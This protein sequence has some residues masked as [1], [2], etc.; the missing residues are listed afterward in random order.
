MFNRLSTNTINWIIIIGVILFIIEIAF[1]NGGV[2]WAALIFGFMLYLGKKNYTAM[3]GKVLF[4]IGLLSLII[5]ILNMIAIRFLIIVFIVL[6]L[7]DY[8]RANKNAE[9]IEPIL[10]I[11]A[12]G[13]P[14][15]ETIIKTNPI[16]QNI[17]FGDQETKETAYEW[18]DINIH[19]GVGNRII[20]LSNTVLPNDTAVIS[21][22]HLVGNITIY[23]PYE[24][25][26][27]I[28]H[29]A[30]FGRVYILNE[31]HHHL[32]NQVL[33]YKTEFYETNVPRVKII[34]SILSGN[35]EVKRI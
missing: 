25:E 2:L 21:I 7:I 28:H 32:M 17:F 27:M 35:V 22:R 10:Y 9:Q 1:F 15:K 29:S 14:R 4:W 23:V 13:S 11:D 30:V 31:Q 5:S 34:T 18:H 24:I 6:F 16:F 33:S 20:D 19:G 8:L 3:W 12:D 26:F